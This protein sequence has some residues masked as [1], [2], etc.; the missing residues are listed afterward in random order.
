MLFLLSL[1]VFMYLDELGDT[2]SSMILSAS[3]L[4]SFLAI[5]ITKFLT[6]SIDYQ[7]VEVFV[8]Y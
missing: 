6:Y 8:M 7:I 2:F 5:V 3:I 1:L 4:Y